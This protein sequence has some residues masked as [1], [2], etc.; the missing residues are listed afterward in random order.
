MATMSERMNAWMHRRTHDNLVENEQYSIRTTFLTVSASRLSAVSI[1]TS[2]A[3]LTHSDK[4]S[5]SSAPF[6]PISSISG[7]AATATAAAAATFPS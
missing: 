1:E 6:I 5:L 4:I 7:T 3:I 2:R